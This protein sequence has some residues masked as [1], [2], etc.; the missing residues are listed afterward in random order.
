[1]LQPVVFRRQKFAQ[2][3]HL[4]LLQRAL[5]HLP[6][7]AAPLRVDLAESGFVRAAAGAVEQPFGA[8]PGRLRAER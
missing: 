6:P 3:A 7:V 4:A 2:L 5:D 1:M 8:A